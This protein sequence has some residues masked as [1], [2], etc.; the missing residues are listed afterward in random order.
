MPG[1]ASK[2]WSQCQIHCKGEK[3]ASTVDIQSNKPIGAG[4]EITVSYGVNYFG[5]NNENCRCTVC[6][7]VGPEME[8]NLDVTEPLFETFVGSS[9]SENDVSPNENNLAGPI[10][11]ATLPV[12]AIANLD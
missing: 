8:S 2:L 11:G 1:P 3:S 6:K 7:Q 12:S 9:G 4:E 10:R 5:E